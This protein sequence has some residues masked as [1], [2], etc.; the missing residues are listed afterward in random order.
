[1]NDNNSYRAIVTRADC[2]QG[3]ADDQPDHSA[4]ARPRSALEE[5]APGAL[6]ALDIRVEVER[7]GIC[8]SDLGIFQTD[9]VTGSILSSVPL[10]I[11]ATGRILGHEGIGIVRQVGRDVTTFRAGDW[12]TMESLICCQQCSACR[13]GYFN[14]CLNAKLLGFQSDGIFAQIAD[15]PVQ[16]AHGIGDMADS[17]EGRRAAA[18]IEPAAC[19]MVA[20]ESASMAP[21]RRVL[22]FG[23]GPI[24]IFTAM[25]CRLVYGAASVDVVEPL[26][27]RRQFAEQWADRSYDVEEFHDRRDGQRYDLLVET[28]GG[29]ADVDRTIHRMGPRSHVVLLARGTAPLHLTAVD[30]VVTN[31]ISIT[32]S[33]GHLGGA[34]QSVLAL[35][36]SGRLPLHRAVTGVLQGFD[37]ILQLLE[38]PSLLNEAHCKLQVRL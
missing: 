33:R 1:M 14:Q 12:V 38:Q 25:M 24:G 7:T 37:S 21:G 22:V 8:G 30:Q 35:W 16:L 9:P 29:L 31:G 13:Q 17:E 20:L 15:I 2:R 27:F 36:Q 3:S 11:P 18:C 34:F 32:G 6:G 4:Y 23:A 19:A 26:R 5:R 10:T 28:S